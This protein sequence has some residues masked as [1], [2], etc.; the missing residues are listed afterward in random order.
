MHAHTHTYRYTDTHRH[1]ETETHRD[2]HIDTHTER[3]RHTQTHTHTHL[4]LCAY[5]LCINFNRKATPALTSNNFYYRPN[6]IIDPIFYY[7][8]NFSFWVLPFFF[9]GSQSFRASIPLKGT[10]RLPCDPLLWFL[11]QLA[12]PL[13]LA[14]GFE[15]L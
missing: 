7:R 2:T 10:T 13:F 3:H 12:Q 6:F 14:R 4:S 11:P 9:P 15:V 8:P 1:T 5:W